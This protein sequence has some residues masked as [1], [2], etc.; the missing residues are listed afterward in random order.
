M[1]LNGKS[2]V[3][4]GEGIGNI[5]QGILNTEGNTKGIVQWV[6]RDPDSYRDREFCEKCIN[7]PTRRG[8]TRSVEFRRGNSG[9]ISFDMDIQ[10]SALNTS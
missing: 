10:R 2:P 9:A 3:R 4:K 5:E 7:P 8:Q 1:V 6:V